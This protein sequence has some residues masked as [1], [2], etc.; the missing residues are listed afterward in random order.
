[1]LSSNGT[2]PRSGWKRVLAKLMA[3]TLIGAGAAGPDLNGTGQQFRLADSPDGYVRLIN[4]D[5]AKTA[6]IQNSA[7]TDGA[8][9]AQN[10]DTGTP[11]NNGNSSSSGRRRKLLHHPNPLGQMISGRPA[12][13][14]ITL[15]RGL[16]RTV[17]ADAGVV[18]HE[19]CPGRAI[20]QTDPDSQPLREG[21]L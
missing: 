14:Q 13:P 3:T 16:N 18:R 2:R 20:G 8:R 7:T 4:R 10:P 1:M 15:F 12:C 5:S 9:L 17:A 11:T 19:T 21:R 6:E